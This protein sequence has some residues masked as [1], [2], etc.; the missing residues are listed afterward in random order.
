MVMKKFLNPYVGIGVVGSIILPRLIA[1]LT[2]W[3]VDFSG[4]VM[5]IVITLLLVSIGFL[6]AGTTGLVKN[7]KVNWEDSRIQFTGALAIVF[8]LY[9]AYYAGWLPIVG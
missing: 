6:L 8:A 7:G 1:Y 3:D 2:G 9:L 5:V 4:I